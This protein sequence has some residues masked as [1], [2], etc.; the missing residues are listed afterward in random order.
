MNDISINS[1]PQYERTFVTPAMAA[2]FLTRNTHNRPKNERTVAD[3]T[4]DIETGNWLENGDS[5]R[6]DW[7]GVMLNGQHTC[8]AIV[9]AG[10]GVF[11]L[12]VTNLDPKTQD[13]MDG[14]RRRTS[15]DMFSLRNET[16]PAS[17]ASITRLVW[18]WENGDRRMSANAQPTKAEQR[19]MVDKYPS[20]R[21][22]NEIAV[23]VRSHF[24]PTWPSVTGLAH[25][26]FHQIDKDQ[27]VW[28]FEQ[29]ATGDDLP[30]GDPVKALRT[31][32]INDSAGQVRRTNAQMATYLI[33]AWNA[34]REGR[35]LARVV[36][37]QGQNIPE[38]K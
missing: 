18:C 35:D 31:K 15:Q 29:F 28:F 3:Y 20:L 34:R 2:E 12:V 16:N 13:T 21:R 36:Y 4:R 25:H 37:T 22:S 19:D 32:M 24:R 33:S 9:R 23:R 26:L 6:F 17:L 7:N 38:P 1:V 27:T 10:I 14:G 5:I 11:A 30:S 8:S